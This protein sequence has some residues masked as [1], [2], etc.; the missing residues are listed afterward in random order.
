M[1]QFQKNPKTRMLTSSHHRNNCQYNNNN[2]SI[3]ILIL[4]Q[5]ESSFTI[6]G[7]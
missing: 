2:I 5:W 1:S 6:K 4:D 7:D 3:R